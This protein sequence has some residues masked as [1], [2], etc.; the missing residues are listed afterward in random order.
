MHIVVSTN[1]DRGHWINDFLDSVPSEFTQ[2]VDV[3][4]GWNF[5]CAAIKHGLEQG[6]EKFLMLQDTCL[7]KNSEFIKLASQYETAWVIPRPSCYLGVYSSR[8]L[9]EMTWP[10]I[11]KNDK[12][13]SITHELAWCDE[14]EEKARAILEIPSMPVIFPELTDGEALSA[15]RFVER[16]GE[17]RLALENEFLAKHKGTFR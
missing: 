3:Y 1:P 5:E 11:E 16:H 4:S 13:S 7:I 14:Y 8:V 15:D 9:E 6:Y 2:Y 10:I 12:E 17:R